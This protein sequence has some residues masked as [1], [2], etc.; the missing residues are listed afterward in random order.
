MK[1]ARGTFC[2]AMLEFQLYDLN[3]LA[4]ASAFFASNPKSAPTA[5]KV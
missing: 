5:T 4:S 1:L 3:R 2:Q